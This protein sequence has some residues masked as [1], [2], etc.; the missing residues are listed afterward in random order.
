V[1]VEAIKLQCIGIAQRDISKEAVVLQ[2]IEHLAAQGYLTKQSV[3]VEAASR[4]IA[5]SLSQTAGDREGRARHAAECLQA[6]GYL[7]KPGFV[8][9][10]VEPTEEMRQIGGEVNC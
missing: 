8:M 9:V 3:D 6:Q 1:D 10:P 4:V 2:T 5:E 7:T